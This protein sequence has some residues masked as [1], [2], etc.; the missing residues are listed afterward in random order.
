MEKHPLH[1]SERERERK[2]ERERERKGEKKREFVCERETER[3]VE[4]VFQLSRIV[5]LIFKR[6]YGCLGTF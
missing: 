4:Y 1:Q 5:I 6:I 3:Y 2:R